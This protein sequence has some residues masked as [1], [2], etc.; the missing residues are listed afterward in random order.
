LG[1]RED[2][3]QA[4]ETAQK[5]RDWAEQA[6]RQNDHAKAERLR[7]HAD[8]IHRH[9]GEGQ[10][11]PVEYEDDT[12]TDVSQGGS[13]RQGCSAMLVGLVALPGA[14]WQMWEWFVR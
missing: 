7:R 10:R 12:G 14:A 11:N 1:S 2:R 5:Y 4:E 6:E 9:Y 13:T 3:Q 8:N